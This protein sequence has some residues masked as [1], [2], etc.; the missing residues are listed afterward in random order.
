MTKT[1]TEAVE[2]EFLKIAR[3]CQNARH[4]KASPFERDDALRDAATALRHAA[5]SRTAKTEPSAAGFDYETFY[6]DARRR[7]M[8]DMT[9]G[10]IDEHLARVAYEAALSAP[11]REREWQPIE[12]APKGP[13]IIGTD[14]D[15][16]R[17]MAWETKCDDDEYTGWCGACTVD[18][19]MLYTNHV[20][21]GFAPTHWQPLPEPPRIDNLLNEGSGR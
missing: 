1:N 9:G 6:K 4:S 8:N 17:P 14:G 5:L 18:G 11:T 20:E 13:W 10:S 2:A 3:R 21:L 7:A 15:H 16:V 19:G 12:T